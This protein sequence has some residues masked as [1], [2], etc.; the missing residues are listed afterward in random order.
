MQGNGEGKV[1]R[2]REEERSAI[3]YVLSRETSLFRDIATGD[4]TPTPSQRQQSGDPL[5][6]TNMSLLG[7][8]TLQTTVHR[9]NAATIPTKLPTGSAF[10]GFTPTRYALNMAN[11]T[12]LR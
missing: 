7:L 5:D 4:S 1:G 10:A 11:T 8:P 2:V 3:T 12:L 9:T 6:Y